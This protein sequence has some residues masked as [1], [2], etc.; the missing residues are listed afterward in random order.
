MKIIRSLAPLCLL[1]AVASAQN[2][3]VHDP[4]VSEKTRA[5]GLKQQRVDA[6]HAGRLLT[7]EFKTKYQDWPS[8]NVTNF[9][10]SIYI[11]GTTPAP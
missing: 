5:L 2:A 8:T 1:T 3:P 4:L 11:E 10:K 9:V 7:A 6:D